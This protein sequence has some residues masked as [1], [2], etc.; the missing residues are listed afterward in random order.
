[1]QRRILGAVAALVMVAGQAQAQTPAAP[2][3]TVSGTAYAQ[4]N[5]NLSGDQHMNAFDVTRTYIN[6]NGKFANGVSTRITPDI[7][8][9]ADGSLGYRLKYGYVSYQPNAGNVTYKFGLI[10]TPFVSRD[11]DLWDYR[12]QGSIAV[13]RNGV[14]S[15]ADFGL[16]ADAKLANGRFD[17]NAGIYNG[18]G[19][20]VGE[21]DQRKDFMVRGSYLLSA[22]NDNS[23]MGGF[24]VT[25]YAGI[26]KAAAGVARE[27][28][29]GQLSYRT[30]QYTLAG[31]YVNVNNGGVK[32]SIISAFGVYHMN[33]QWALIGRVDQVDPNTDADNDAN[34]RIIAGASYQL[35]PNLRLLG[36]VDLLSHEAG[37]PDV[38]VDPRNQALFQLQFTF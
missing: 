12:M 26:G 29:L 37:D 32:G 10:Q 35:S 22:T 19:Y 11:E 18:E 21:V 6:F 20:K 14:M 24:R 30:T 4:W 9:N 23:S 13:D 15:S 36:D 27:R 3:L 8:R 25:G 17:L 5:Y 34:T 38:A 7:Y 33:S 2:Q 1:M 31:E 28:Y 16:S